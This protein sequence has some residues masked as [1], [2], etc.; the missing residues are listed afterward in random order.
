[1]D[2]R[3]RPLAL[4]VVVVLMVAGAPSFAQQPPGAPAAPVSAPPAGVGW[5]SLSP[6]QQRVLS[7]F[8]SQWNT[9]PPERQQ[10]LAH[11]SDRWLGMSD[12]QR[13]QAR[14]RFSRWRALPPEQRQALRSRWQ[15]FQE[16]PPGEQA[17]VREN[18]RRFQQLPPERREMLRQQWRNATPAQRQQW[19]ERARAQHPGHGPGAP[20]A[21]M[22]P[23]HVSGPPPHH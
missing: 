14:E 17:R 8:G 22:A 2:N 6:D 4:T 13:D 15:R 12:T 23:P 18:Y 16:L 1:M 19:V 10:A 7:Q 5:S 11:G 21:H 9:L 20:G 3:W